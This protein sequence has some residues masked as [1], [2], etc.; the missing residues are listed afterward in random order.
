MA[1]LQRRIKVSRKRILSVALYPYD[2]EMYPYIRCSSMLDGIKIKFLISPKNWGVENVNVCGYCI[3]S[4]LADD[5]F[6]KIDAVWICDSIGEVNDESLLFVSEKMLSNG[7][8]IIM[9]RHTDFD[10]YEKISELAKKYSSTIISCDY[11]SDNLELNDNLVYLEHITKPIVSVSGPGENTDKFLT[12][13][14]LKEYLE[15]NE[16]KVALVSSRINSCLLKG[17]YSF[18]NFMGNNDM[19]A[20]RKIIRYNHMVKKI[21][22]DTNPDIIIVGIPGSVLPS[23]KINARNFE[24]GPYSVFKAVKPLYSIMCL[25]GNHVSYDYLDELRQTMKYKYGTDVDFYYRSSLAVDINM[26]LGNNSKTIESIY[27]NM[28]ETAYIYDDIA[29]IGEIIV[30][31]SKKF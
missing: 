19:S 16:Y 10:V 31:K 9:T 24:L 23:A 4:E 2:D 1:R 26:F 13:L 17:V 22:R 6:D 15:K 25:Y 7:K 27:A 28:D 20:E 30:Q 29:R 8:Q 12:Q 11:Y 21:E 18:P 5:D 14:L 3:K